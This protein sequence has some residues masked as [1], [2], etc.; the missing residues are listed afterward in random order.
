MFED[1]GSTTCSTGITWPEGS[2]YVEAELTVVAALGRSSETRSSFGHGIPD[3]ADEGP[4]LSAGSDSSSGG[5]DVA[6]R[7]A[8]K[9]P[10][11][12]CGPIDLAENGPG[13]SL[14]AELGVIGERPRLLGSKPPRARL[15]RNS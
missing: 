6:A 14:R 4:G 11:A 15:E 3:G 9:G 10:I 5:F 2:T 12:D 8:E 13:H 7:P 1:S